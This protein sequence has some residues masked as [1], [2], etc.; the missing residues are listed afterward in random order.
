MANNKWT[1][2]SVDTMKANIIE[3]QQAKSAELFG[4]YKWVTNKENLLLCAMLFKQVIF[5]L[6]TESVQCLFILCGS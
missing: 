1:I 3:V 5:Q 6:V 2:Y 4:K